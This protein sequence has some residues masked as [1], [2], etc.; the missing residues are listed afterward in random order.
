MKT[1]RIPPLLA[2]VAGLSLGTA[3]AQTPI[4]PASPTRSGD[5]G[6][7]HTKTPDDANKGGETQRP[8]TDP[9]KYSPTHTQTG[10]AVDTGTPKDNV[11]KN[12]NVESTK[13]E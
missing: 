2:A 5:G 3:A 11:D 12:K 8:V 10:G 6:V 1:T 13:S 9:P 7:Q 4:T